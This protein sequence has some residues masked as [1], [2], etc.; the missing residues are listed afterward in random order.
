M[1]DAL[2]FQAFCSD[3]SARVYCW[4]RSDKGETTDSMLKIETDGYLYH[5]LSTAVLAL[6]AIILN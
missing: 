1:V 3:Q 4:G 5:F 2:R 6:F